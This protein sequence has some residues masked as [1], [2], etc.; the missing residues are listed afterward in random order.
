MDSPSKTDEGLQLCTP[1]E[2]PLTI[3]EKS[4]GI[5]EKFW[6]A[7]PIAKSCS[8]IAAE[9][10]EMLTF[11]LSVLDQEGMTNC[12]IHNLHELTNSFQTQLAN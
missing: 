6:L 9:K 12:L 1:D 2:M 7:S 5:W 3:L 10:D 4:Q 8:D 11:C